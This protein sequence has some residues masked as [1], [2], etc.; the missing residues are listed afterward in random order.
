MNRR[1]RHGLHVRV[2]EE[3]RRVHWGGGG[4]KPRPHVFRGLHP[5]RNTTLG[6][7]WTKEGMRAKGRNGTVKFPRIARTGVGH[8]QSPR[9]DHVSH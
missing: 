2:Y 9:S 8:G 5:I 4:S 1:F 3:A 7:S 6:D